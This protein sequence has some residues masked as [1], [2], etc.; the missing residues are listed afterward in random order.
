MSSF[1]KKLSIQINRLKVIYRGVEAN[2]E[3]IFCTLQTILTGL[4][5]KLIVCFA[6]A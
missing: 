6:K 2:V 4:L 1:N 3:V 5:G